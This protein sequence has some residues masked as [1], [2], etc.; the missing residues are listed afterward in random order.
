[1]L[2][3]DF[4]RFSKIFHNETPRNTQI[5]KIKLRR[6][7]INTNGKRIILSI[8]ENFRR[9]AGLKINK[10][11]YLHFRYLSNFRAHLLRISFI[12]LVKVYVFDCFLAMASDRA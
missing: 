7:S 1:M 10:F 11:H 6:I 12:Y 3:A 2:Q 5:I 8:N 9:D 4:Q